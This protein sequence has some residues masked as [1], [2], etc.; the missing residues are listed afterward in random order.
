MNYQ[1]GSQSAFEAAVQWVNFVL[2]GPLSTMFGVIAVALVG[3]AMLGGRFE[4]RRTIHLIV[5]SFILFGSSALARGLMDL[6]DA[7]SGPAVVYRS[8]DIPQPELPPKAS[9]A[10][11][12]FD[13]YAGASVP[14]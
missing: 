10:T 3:F 6:T 9:G 2:T 8:V 4:G 12:P 5:G 1:A 7:G 14:Q 13:P 11:N